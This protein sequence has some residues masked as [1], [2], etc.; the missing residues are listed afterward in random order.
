MPKEWAQSVLT[1]GG[2]VGTEQG[3]FTMVNTCPLDNFLWICYCYY[4]T[5]SDA[6]LYLDES[7]EQTIINFKECVDH[8]FIAKQSFYGLIT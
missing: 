3:L 8:L 2:N 5:N 1:W 7:R 4:T 6:L